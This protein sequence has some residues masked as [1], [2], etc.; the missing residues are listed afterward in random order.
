MAGKVN[1]SLSVHTFTAMLIPWDCP[2]EGKRPCKLAADLSLNCWRQDE[3]GTEHYCP[4]FDWAAR[5]TDFTIRLP[6]LSFYA[7]QLRADGEQRRL[8]ALRCQ[9]ARGEETP[10][11]C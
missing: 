4:Y 6:G 9:L 1:A 2:S 8:V 10:A 5:R 3:D 11:G 7:D